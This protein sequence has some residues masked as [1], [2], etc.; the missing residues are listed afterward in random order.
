MLVS[1]FRG[2]F[3]FTLKIIALLIITSILAMLAQQA[4]AQGEYVISAVLA[5]A[6]IAINFVYLTKKSVPL[7]FFLPGLL[8][9]FAFVVGPIAYTV[10]MSG[11]QYQTGN[12][13]SKP[14]AIEQL[15]KLG[16]VKDPFETIFDVTIGKTNNGELGLIYFDSL[17]NEFAVSTESKRLPQFR[18]EIVFDDFD[19]PLR[20]S[21]FTEINTDE[22]SALDAQIPSLK[23]FYNDEY[24][25]G[26]EGFQVDTNR[27][28]LGLACAVVKLAVV[29]GAF[30]QMVHHQAISQMNIFMGAFARRGIKLAIG[31][32]VNRISRPRMIKADQVFGFDIGGGTSVNPG[33]FSVLRSFSGGLTQRAF[34]EIHAV[35]FSRHGQIAL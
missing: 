26:L 21:E 4:L 3:A 30:D 12:T 24:Y 8:F 13:L 10:T 33:H 20:S 25:L 17:K 9:L 32:M 22:L 15:V 6:T 16:T 28:A 23:F 27:R 7:K 5:L 18:A 14:E 35:R 29:L 11:F 19:I 2:K 31:G 1:V 34:V